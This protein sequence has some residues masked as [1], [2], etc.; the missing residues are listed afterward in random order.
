MLLHQ[1]H[2]EGDVRLRDDDQLATDERL[3]D[4]VHDQAI[5]V[6]ERQRTQH[7]LW[8]IAQARDPVL[9]LQN[10]G[11][12]VA[13]G[14]LRALWLPRGAGGVHDDRHGVLGDV[15]RR[16]DVAAVAANRVADEAIPGHGVLCVGRKL[17]ALGL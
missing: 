1:V 17:L 2:D 5:S 9:A 8:L 10:H 6:E 12:E 7:A 11:K 14:K 16:R 13:V 4:D 15:L 3:Q